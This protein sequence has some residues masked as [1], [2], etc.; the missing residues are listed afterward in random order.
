MSRIGKLPITI[1]DGV[2]VTIDNRVVTV[3]GPKGTLTFTHHERATVTMAD[4][5]ITVTVR[6]PN[7]QNDRALW[8]LTRMLVANMIIGVTTGYEKKLE[9][10]GV[11]FKAAVAGSTIT[12]NL[13][14]SHPIEFPIPD[15]LKVT[16]EKNVV[17]ISG[18]DKQLV[19]ETAA[20]IRALK[21]PEPYKGKGIKYSDEIIRRKA[22]KVVKAAGA[23]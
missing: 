12:F 22:G 10:N 14:F 11:G 4:N 17:A 9:I 5:V 19:G 13:G 8:G 2:T 15:G 21:K 1:P 16:V 3:T 23:K 18:I 7:N 20:T 6:Q